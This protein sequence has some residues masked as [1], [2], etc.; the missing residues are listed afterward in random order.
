MRNKKLRFLIFK[1]IYPQFLTLIKI[2]WVLIF[3]MK[4]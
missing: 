4:T 3:K 2:K 1:S